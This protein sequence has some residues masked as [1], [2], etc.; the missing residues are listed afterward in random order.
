MNTPPFGRAP[1]AAGPAWNEDGSIKEIWARWFTALGEN[2]SQAS[3]SGEVL[4]IAELLDRAKGATAESVTITALG[5]LTGGYNRPQV[6]AGIVI[7]SPAARVP[8]IPTSALFQRPYT[9]PL[10]QILVCTQP[11]FP[12]LSLLAP[13]FI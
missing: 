4:S 7:P 6:D 2:L 1:I 8:E 5:L 3:G 10:P 9:K 13:I 12:T 11:T